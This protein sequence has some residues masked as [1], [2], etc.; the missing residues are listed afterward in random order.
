MSKMNI[1]NMSFLAFKPTENF[2]KFLFLKRE[3][4]FVSYLFK[5]TLLSWVWEKQQ[6]Q[7][8]QNK[9]PKLVTKVDYFKY[10]KLIN[11]IYIHI[12][13]MIKFI[14]GNWKKT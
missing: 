4:L 6:Q 5:I 11:I 10:S 14:W 2:G 3:I 8:Q 9:Y 12:V 7:E 1:F 13:I